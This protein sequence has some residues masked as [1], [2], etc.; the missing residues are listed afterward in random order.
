MT[1]QLLGELFRHAWP[2]LC[3]SPGAGPPAPCLSAGAPSQ[4]GHMRGSRPHALK[5]AVRPVLENTQL[6]CARRW[7]VSRLHSAMSLFQAA[8]FAGQALGNVDAQET[9]FVHAG[10]AHS[11]TVSEH[12]QHELSDAFEYAISEIDSMHARSHARTRERLRV[13]D[14]IGFTVAQATAGELQDALGSISAAAA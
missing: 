14:T 3:L 12:V 7:L 6:S 8:T 9:G 13:G 5:I 4:T 10:G 1:H 2:A 11:E